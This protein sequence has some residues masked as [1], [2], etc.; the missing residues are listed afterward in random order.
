M[1]IGTPAVGDYVGAVRRRYIYLVTILPGVLFL[2]VVAAFAIHPQYQATATILLEP[3]SVP[4][5]IIE[6]THPA[7]CTTYTAGAV[8]GITG[9]RQAPRSILTS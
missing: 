3:S 2:C 5:D 1:A 8:A 9:Q 6:T 4:K 7:Q